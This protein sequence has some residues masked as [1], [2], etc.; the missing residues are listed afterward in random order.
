[1][2]TYCAV[3][4]SD[5]CKALSTNAEKL[6]YTIAKWRVLSEEK[7]QE[8]KEKAK[9]LEAF[10]PSKL[11]NTKRRNEVLKTQRQLTSQV[12]CTGIQDTGNS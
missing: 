11:S 9:D 1:M 10:N 2:L 7:Q 3:S 8:W 12:C 5:E 6:Q 4:L